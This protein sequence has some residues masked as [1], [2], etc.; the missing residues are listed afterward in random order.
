M[1]LVL[2]LPSIQIAS[3]G[4]RALNR[5]LY[6]TYA[7]LKRFVDP[8][9]QQH[10]QAVQ[11]ACLLVYRFATEPVYGFDFTFL[12]PS[13]R[14]ALVSIVDAIDATAAASLEEALKTLEDSSARFQQVRWQFLKNDPDPTQLRQV[15]GVL[16]SATRLFVDDHALPDHPFYRNWY[17][18]LDPE[19]TSEMISLPD[20]RNALLS[21]DATR[22]P[23][24]IERITDRLRSFSRVLV[25][26][27]H[28]LEQATPK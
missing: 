1:E 22:L 23:G 14:E 16:A 5:T 25:S 7:S 18:G 10:K 12:A 9:F 17:A 2:G 24:A 19:N 13:I 6:D 11:L 28:H 21:I 20:L 8:E 27:S 4:P 15:N 3:S 26:L